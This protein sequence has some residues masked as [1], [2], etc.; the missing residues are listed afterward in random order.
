L[1]RVMFDRAD[2]DALIDAG[3]AGALGETVDAQA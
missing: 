1:R 2:L 3:K